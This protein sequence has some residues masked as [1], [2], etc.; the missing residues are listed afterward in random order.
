MTFH[1]KCLFGS[2]KSFVWNASLPTTIMPTNFVVSHS[3]GRMMAIKTSTLMTSWQNNAGQ[4]H[5]SME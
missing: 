3:A 2:N 1:G 5:T 4:Q